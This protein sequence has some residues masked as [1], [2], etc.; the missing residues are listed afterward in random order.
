MSSDTVAPEVPTGSEE[1]QGV[2]A[3]LEALLA[4][5]DR[6]AGAWATEWLAHN[7]LPDPTAEM[8][9]YTPLDSIVAELGR[10][11]TGDPTGE[12]EMADL[13]RLAGRHGSTRIVFVDGRYSS[14]LSDETG[15]SDSAGAGSATGPLPPGVRVGPLGAIASAEG[16]GGETTSDAATALLGTWAATTAESAGADDGFSV[17]NAAARNEAAVVSVPAGVAVGSPVHIVHLRTGSAEPSA[18]TL[19]QPATILDIGAGASAQVIESHVSTGPGVTNAVT[20]VR[21]GPDANLTHVRVQDEHAEAVHVGETVIDL[22]RG[23]H[24]ESASLSI[25]AQVARN[26]LSVGLNGESA[27]AKLSGL[28]I[29]SGSQRHDTVLSIDHDSTDCR[30]E[31]DFRSVVDDRA[32]SS[33]CGHVR[34]AHGADGTDASQ[35][36]RNL[37]LSRT[38]QVDTRPWLEILADDVKCNH[39]ATVGQLDDEALFYLRSRGVPVARATSML[40]AAFVAEI[41]ERLEPESLRHAFDDAIRRLDPDVVLTTAAVRSD[42]AD[43]EEAG[44]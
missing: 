37:L 16:A 39:G 13:D 1:G 32:R 34:V 26:G 33:F 15:R 44:S 17:L 42:A 2:P 30:S 40:V 43:T 3:A 35:S 5:G 14:Q 10:T 11:T 9:R 36:N 20:R 27:V 31:Q 4:A 24:L 6:S 8:W 7:G 18:A 12:V 38:A 21:V 19:S 25:G 23:A 41:T 29:L 22:Q 28:S